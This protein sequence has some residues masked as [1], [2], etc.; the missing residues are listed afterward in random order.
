MKRVAAFFDIDGTI[1]REGLI[2]ELFK[3]LIKHELVDESVWY[4][5]VRQVFMKYDRRQ[6]DYDSYLDAMV[7]SYTRSI[8]GVNRILIDHIATKVIEQKGD[9]VYVF[10]RD[11]IRYHKA[12]N[13]LLLAI[14]GSPIELVEKMA[15]KYEFDDY[16]G[17]IYVTDDS[18]CYTDQIIPMWDSVSKSNA[19]KKLVKK[20]GIDLEQSYA[21]GDTVGDFTMFKMVGHPYAI[22]PTKA[23][24]KMIYEDEQV[25]KKIK[26]IVERKN[27]IYEIKMS[28]VKFLDLE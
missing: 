26:V 16:R 12:Q 9:R 22:N 11:Q 24:L 25:A 10:S 6:G 21:Y 28:D 27:V 14:S 13:N 8:L 1:Y 19:I 5:G 17:T 20:Y 23:L 7:D 3:K 15:R 4:D 18:N 2:T